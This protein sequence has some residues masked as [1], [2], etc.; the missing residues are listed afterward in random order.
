LQYKQEVV[1]TPFSSA[2]CPLRLNRSGR[3]KKR[4]YI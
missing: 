1:P 4:L 2:F 3:H